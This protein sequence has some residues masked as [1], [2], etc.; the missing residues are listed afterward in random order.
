[1][2]SF[3]TTDMNKEERIELRVSSE[4]KAM[5]KRAQELSG[6][7]SLSSFAVRLLKAESS[8]VIT[9]RNQILV[10]ER[11]KK[12]FFDAVF[13]PSPPNEALIAAAIRYN[14]IIEK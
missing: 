13:N 12:V 6:D 8:R 10:S 14:E 9:E 5:F 2:T 7:S 11:D 4:E 1:M 3:T